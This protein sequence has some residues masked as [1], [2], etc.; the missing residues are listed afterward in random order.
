MEYDIYFLKNHAQKQV[1]NKK[2]AH[3]DSEALR[4]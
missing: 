3:I 2:I 4:E 1:L